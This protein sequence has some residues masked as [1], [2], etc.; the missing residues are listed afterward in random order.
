MDIDQEPTRILALLQDGEKEVITWSPVRE[1]WINA[2]I[3]ATFSAGCLWDEVG[4]PQL[5]VKR[6]LIIDQAK[7][8]T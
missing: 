7:E 6:A 1:R 8:T 2:A 4:E 5:P 3:C